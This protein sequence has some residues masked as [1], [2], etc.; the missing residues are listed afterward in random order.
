[1]VKRILISLIGILLF[2]IGTLLFLLNEPL[3][4]IGFFILGSLVFPFTSK[5]LN[6]IV[7]EKKWLK[8]TVFITVLMIMIVAVFSFG[9][10][11]YYEKEP[12]LTTLKHQLSKHPIKKIK[13]KNGMD[14]AYI[15]KG[16]GPVVVLLHGFP[17]LASTWDNTISD[18][19]KD[20][21]VIAPFLRGYYPT[22]IP[23]DDNYSVKVV[24]ED[25]IMLLNEKKV[26]HFSVVG[27]DWGASVAQVMG[28]VA[29]GKV[30]KI[31]SVAIPHPS[32]FEPTFGLLWAGRHFFTLSTGDYGV[33]Y[34]RKNDFEYIHRLYQ[35]W[36]PDY[37]NYQKSSEPII[38]TFKY[39]ER[40]K[41]ALGYYRSFVNETAENNAFYQ[42]VPTIPICFMVGE[43]DA[44]ATPEVVAK[45]RTSMPKGS[46][47][48]VFKN[49]GHFLHQ[50]VFNEFIDELRTF[51]K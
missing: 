40:L 30:Q 3:F 6:K 32:C 44:I 25:I 2:F 21:R 38:E 20:H 42:Q 35:R 24:A 7:K 22:G 31:V 28:N 9:R 37:T 17:D 1:M 45:M 15:E 41:A 43:N 16:E 47:T 19:A 33:R 34:A 48:I 51:L 12:D 26:T 39:P 8:P 11:A 27:Q 50:E 46:K 23:S 29:E 5:A 13:L 49:A 18:L 14:Y 4:G 36:S 10:T